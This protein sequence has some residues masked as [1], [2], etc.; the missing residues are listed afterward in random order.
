M[1]A[2]HPMLPEAPMQH[3]PIR[4][5]ALTV[6]VFAQLSAL[7][8]L[9]CGGC[10]SPPAPTPDQTVLQDAERVLFVRDPLTK[11]STVWVEVR[12]TGLATD[13]GWVL[14][15]PKLPIVGVGTAAVFDAFDTTMQAT[16]AFQ[17]GDPENCRD[18]QQG[19]ASHQYPRYGPGGSVDAAFADA[20]SS[21][22]QDSVSG[23]NGGVEIVSSGHTGPY[24]YVV[25]KGSDSAVL[26]KWL[27][28][29]GYAMP[30][31][32]KPIIQSH[33]DQGNLFVAVKL[34]N[35]KGIEAIRPITLQMDDAEP[36]VPLRLTSIAAVDDMAVVVTI[37]GPGRAIVKNHLDVTVNPLRLALQGSSGYGPYCQDANGSYVVCFVPSNYAQ[38]V[39]AAIDEASGHAFVTEYAAPPNASALK[40]I[41][42][43][44]N[45]ATAAAAT[46]LA[47]FAMALAQG[48]LP[49]T[50]EVADALEPQLQLAKR[51]PGI[52][53]V[54]MLANLRACGQF[55]NGMVGSPCNLGSLSLTQGQL[56]ALPVDA[57]AL[58][59]QVTSTLIA[60]I[61]AVAKLM[62][63]S[64]MVTRL[65]MRISPSEMDRDP[66]FAFNPALPQV[67]R[68]RTLKVNPVCRD[69]WYDDNVG[70]RLTIDELGSWITD[71]LSVDPRFAKTPA[72]WS[73]QLLDETGPAVEIAP[74]DAPVVAAAILGAKPG[75]PSLAKDL[76]LTTPA[77]WLPPE[78]DPLLTKMGPWPEPPYCVPK[79]GWVSGQVPPSGVIDT[80]PDAIGDGSGGTVPG[81]DAQG[82][83]KDVGESPAGDASAPAKS[84]CTAGRTAASGWLALAFAFALVLRR[85]AT[86]HG[87]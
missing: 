42:G 76:V 35:G 3:F 44:F 38:V 61:D 19:C 30:D 87:G 39:A 84:G 41:Y 73:M 26:F 24:N 40:Q 86:P 69:G 55:W 37:A 72:A 83:W 31:K 32:A 1:L 66:V 60:P 81:V 63:S 62:A 6:L 27:N 64:Q 15:V 4:A 22:D 2:A 21:T 67:S 49:V 45:H 7:D 16:L 74:K 48:L 47:K 28:D 65:Q 5:A 10:F 80:F 85:R 82:G 13:F 43:N 75:K 78:S 56:Q 33:I 20:S 29:N 57:V 34:Q 25:V 9:A 18:P 46:D 51:F 8:A 70:V 36:C 54:Q 71:G 50:D 14:P 11:Q 12:Y 23:G 52:A 17:Q 68:T 77:P 53:P 58:A 79:L 59:D